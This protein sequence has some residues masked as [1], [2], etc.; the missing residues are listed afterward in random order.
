M[1]VYLHGTQKCNGPDQFIFGLDQPLRVKLSQYKFYLFTIFKLFQ[2]ASSL[3]IVWIEAYVT[4]GSSFWAKPPSS[5]SYS[6]MR[7]LKIRPLV[8]PH[9][10]HMVGNGLS[11]SF[12]CDNWSTSCPLM[13]PGGRSYGIPLN[14]TVAGAKTLIA[15][16]PCHTRDAMREEIGEIAN[17]THLIDSRLDQTLWGY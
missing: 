12:W 4:K 16:W 13:A 8:Y 1:S 11:T 9:L 7:I 17:G 2:Q 14:A 3:W 10:K 6:L 15:T 5:R